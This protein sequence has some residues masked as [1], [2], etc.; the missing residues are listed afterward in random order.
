MLDPRNSRGD[1]A[2]G[3]ASIKQHARRLSA[4][5]DIDEHGGPTIA[6]ID[7][8]RIL[9]RPRRHLRYPLSHVYGYFGLVRLTA[10]GRDMPRAKALSLV[11]EPDAGNLPVRLRHRLSDFAVTHN[12]V[13][14]CVKVSLLGRIDI[15]SLG[16]TS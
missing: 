5:Q 4:Q 2:G 9:H 15:D 6:W 7:R 8:H 14:A 13:F 16:R 12:S 10:L 11:Q 1:Q 3:C